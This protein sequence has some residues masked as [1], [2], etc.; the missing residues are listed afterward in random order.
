MSFNF[1]RL[2]DHLEP[3]DP[4]GVGLSS[5]VNSHHPQTVTAGNTSV[6]NLQCIFMSSALVR[7]TQEVKGKI[8]RS[9]VTWGQVVR[10]AENVI[11]GFIL[12]VEVQLEPSLI[13][14]YHMESFIYSHVV[15][16]HKLRFKGH[17]M[18]SC[19]LY[20]LYFLCTLSSFII[21]LGKKAEHRN[22]KTMVGALLR[23][24]KVTL[25]NLRSALQL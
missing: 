4:T 25:S 8:S 7:K 22:I 14:W 17:Q 21:F 6:W 20:A 5:G 9:K 12:I 19:A 2:E 3:Y 11:F 10:W 18:S 13:Y 1:F 24:K 16:S 23:A 15:N